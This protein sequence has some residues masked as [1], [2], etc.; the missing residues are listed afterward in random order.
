MRRSYLSFQMGFSSAGSAAPVSLREIS[1]GLVR[2]QVSHWRALLKSRGF[3]LSRKGLLESLPETFNKEKECL[4][5]K[6]QCILWKRSAVHIC[7]VMSNL[8]NQKP[9][10]SLQCSKVASWLLSYINGYVKN[11]QPIQLSNLKCPRICTICDSHE[12]TQ[13]KNSV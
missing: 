4:G 5:D 8:G 7:Q 13:K 12:N 2:Q 9:F 10:D 6:S 11:R 3:F 1:R